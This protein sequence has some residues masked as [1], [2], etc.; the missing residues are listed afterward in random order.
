MGHAVRV[1]R[2]HRHWLSVF[3]IV[4]SAVRV[5]KCI[6]EK[7]VYAEC[8][9]LHELPNW[10]SDAAEGTR[11]QPQQPDA[12]VDWQS[13]AVEG[14]RSPLQQADESARVDWRIRRL[15]YFVEV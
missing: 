7:Y 13:D 12:R 15:V 14:T 2:A 6:L 11:S 1:M 9:F 3:V 8:T 4:H 10:Q 5:K